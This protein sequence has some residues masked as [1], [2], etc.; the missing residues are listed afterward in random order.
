MNRPQLIPPAHA[1]LTE[2]RKLEQDP[3]ASLTEAANALGV[4]RATVARWIRER[5]VMACRVGNR[6]KLRRSVILGL[7]RDAQD[8]KNEHA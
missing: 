3:L 2:W 1:A 7:I 8:G 5:R 4:S 6:L